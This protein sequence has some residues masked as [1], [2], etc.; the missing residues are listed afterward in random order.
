[1]R[2][3]G[4]MGLRVEIRKEMKG[5]GFVV[6]PF[7]QNI[8]LIILETSFWGLCREGTFSEKIGRETPRKALKSPSLLPDLVI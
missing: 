7:Q 4:V 3:K 8:D 1:M 6:S 2:Q 5:K